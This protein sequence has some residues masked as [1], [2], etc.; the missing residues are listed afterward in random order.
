[1][2]TVYTISLVLVWFILSPIDLQA[3]G[4]ASQPYRQYCF[5]EL[6]PNDSIAFGEEEARS[7]QVRH[8]ANIR[9]MVEEKKLLLAGPFMDGGGLFILNTS[10]LDE[11]R[12]WVDNDPAVMAGRFK[13]KIK[14]WITE[15]GLLSL[16]SN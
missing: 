12:L 4:V 8:M 6:M 14:L 2:K 9:R 5:V 11:A 10:Q 15:K 13:Y 1:M 7:I 16:E 3:Q